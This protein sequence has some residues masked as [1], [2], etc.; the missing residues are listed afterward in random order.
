MKEFQYGIG[1]SNFLFMGHL[2]PITIE[3]LVLLIHKLINHCYAVQVWI[4]RLF[5]MI[6]MKKSL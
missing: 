4:Q 2:I 1:Q 3:Q 5:F 6:L